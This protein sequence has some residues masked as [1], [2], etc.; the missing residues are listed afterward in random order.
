MV[1]CMEFFRS[2][3]RIAMIA[4]LA[5]LV[6]LLFFC[7]RFFQGNDIENNTG[8]YSAAH[9]HIQP[10]LKPDTGRCELRSRVPDDSMRMVFR[11]GQQKG[12]IVALINDIK[13][14]RGA[15]LTEEER[16][17]VI[18][19]LGGEV[20][21]AG[22]GDAGFHWLADELLTLLRAQQP[23]W[24]ELP[25]V[26]ERVAFQAN[27]DPVVRDYIMQHLGHWWEQTGHQSGIEAALWRG[28]ET[29]DSTTPATAL[30]ALARGYEREGQLDH[31]KRVHAKAF[32]LAQDHSSS[33]AVRVTAI[34]LAGDS[35]GQEV[36]EYA[37]AL[38]VRSDTPEIFKR[39][40]ARIAH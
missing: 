12:N 6:G 39:A 8:A 7:S 9:E 32:V 13:E 24:D 25:E 35:G 33:L 30:I 34:S 26:L 17:A 31:L 10:E 23:S 37:R 40:A 5:L 19:V 38:V 22:I 27:T 2:T 11:F 3:S 14:L 18:G 16:K 29:H 21:P 20:A 28:V 15:F 36:K 4:A 1:N